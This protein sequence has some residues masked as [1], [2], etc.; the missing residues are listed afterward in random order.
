ME[1]LPQLFSDL[2][3]KFLLRDFFGKIVPGSL[4]LAAMTCMYLQPIRVYFGVMKARVPIIALLI[5]LAWTTTLGL[6]RASEIVG[7]WQ[8]FPDIAPFEENIGDK[9][10]DTL[11]NE[12]EMQFCK[13]TMR[14]AVFFR[15]AKEGEKLQYERFVI[16]KE[17]TG[18]LF[19]SFVLALPAILLVSL[20]GTWLQDVFATGRHVYLVLCVLVLL[21]GL[22]AMNRQHVLRQWMYASGMIG[23]HE[24]L[25]KR[26]PD[27]ETA[28][29]PA[30]AK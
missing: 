1:G 11:Q 10:C 30:P 16:I 3:N 28:K 2:Y 25:G 23:Q 5:G 4:L 18:N 24:S 26:C 19:A 13:H 14:T 7:V 6:Q 21:S 17:A 29:L 12:G 27:P 15:C 22:Y 20:R 8:Y 9:I